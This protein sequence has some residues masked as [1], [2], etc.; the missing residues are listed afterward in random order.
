MSPRMDEDIEEIAIIGM[1]G[2]FPGAPDIAALWRLLLRKE[3]GI[4]TLSREELLASGEPPES[5]DDPSYVPRG[6]FL[7]DAEC[8][9][10]DF[11]G[12]PAS[13]ASHTDPQQRLFLSHSYLALE[14]AGYAPG[15]IDVPVAVFAG[16]GPPSYWL[17]Q[18]EG[19]ISKDLKSF[20]SIINND[21]DFIATRTSYRLDLRGPS[22]DVQTACSTSLV[23]V[24]LACQSLLT[25]SCDMALAGGVAVSAPRRRGYLASAGMINSP[26]GICR[27]FDAAADGT[28]VGEGVGVVCLK[29][30]SEAVEDGDYVYAVIKA[31]AIN[32]DGAG[33]A[34]FTAPS[35]EGQMRA[36]ELAQ[37]LAGVE[38]GELGFIEAHG[39]G[40][41]IGDPIEVRALTRAF[42]RKTDK[43]G[44]CRLGSIKANLG[45]LDAAAGITGLIKAVLAVNTGIVPPMRNF[46]SP[47][48]L[49]ELESS[50][51]VV[52]REAERW[53]G[54][55]GRRLAGVSS[56]GIGGTNAHA[57]VESPPRARS[58]ASGNADE[59]SIVPLLLCAKDPGALDAYKK[60]IAD[61]IEGNP[62]IPVADIALRISRTRSVLP[63]RWASVVSSRGGLAE[64]LRDASGVAEHGAPRQAVFAFPGQGSQF[65]GMARAYYGKLGAFTELIDR[66][67]EIAAGLGIRDA[68]RYLLLEGFDDAVSETEIAQP[69]LYIVEYALAMEIVAA[70]IEPAA[71]VGHSVGEYAAAAVGGALG[72]EDGLRL[73]ARRGYWMQRAPRGAMTAVAASYEQVLPLLT[74]GV[75][76]S[77]FNAATQ[78]VVSGAGGDIAL[79]EERTSAAGI[80][81]TRIRTSHAFHSP[82][83]DGILGSYAKDVQEAVFT[84]L[85]VPMLSNL[86]GAWIDSSIDW[87]EYCVRQ[88]RQA[89]RFDEC[90]RSLE[91]MS[92]PMV[93][94]VGPGRAL[95][96]FVRSSSSA[97]IGGLAM[98]PN[99]KTDEPYFRKGL[100]RLWM[101]GLPV[102]WPKMP[103]SDG[104]LILFS[105]RPFRMDR[106][107]WN[108]PGFRA[109]D[110]PSGTLVAE[111]AA[112]SIRNIWRRVLGEAP[113]SDDASFFLSGGDSFAGIQ[114]V[115]SLRRDMGMEIRVQDLL[116]H[117]SVAAL[118]ILHDRAVP[119]A[120]IADSDPFLFPI[121]T[122][123]SKPLLFL[124]A[125]A[126]ENR[127]F[128]PVLGN[129]YEE[130]FF[131]Y[132]SNMIANLGSEQPLYGFKPKG[133][134]MGERIHS[135][136]EIMATRYLSSMKRIQPRGPYWIGG[137]CVG[138]IVAYEMARQLAAE[139]EPV[140][141]LILM[142]TPRP[143][144]W[145]AIREDALLS[146]RDLRR[147]WKRLS[148]TLKSEGLL[149]CLAALRGDLRFS[150]AI[151]FPVGRERRMQ[152]RICNGSRRYQRILFKYRPKGFEGRTS[153]LVNKE[154]NRKYLMMGWRRELG[155]EVNL[156]EI[157]GDHVTRLTVSGGTVGEIIK[158]IIDR[159]N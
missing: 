23:A 156:Y 28:L 37:E 143:T 10:A 105:G 26:T 64:E 45:H 35:V 2:A 68:R 94:E 57:I 58:T 77:V 119:S 111:G 16:E 25:W 101:S 4:S 86:D 46:D 5:I 50:P 152:R 6:G 117:P 61:F 99:A 136:V 24:G 65:S 159:R 30:L 113:S 56:F 115:E 7:D 120:P 38:P 144:L 41:P 31:V 140:A 47:N 137:E 39:T 22:I 34:G 109:A 126:H 12:I 91:R 73:V 95:T 138:G 18:N 53:E 85:R 148:G 106:F 154:W 90:I 70:G 3:E 146:Y 1:S 69:L 145:T 139:G 151:L 114:M 74:E 98:L 51:F 97:K 9:D 27:P 62:D 131:R 116:L 112:A 134:A 155:N 78:V 14:D 13:E 104:R 108:S 100:A 96:G 76:V 142:D 102:I 63:C 84:P 157:P 17:L 128:D 122:G 48:P 72:F 40:T 153:L 21:K 89:V 49:L 11:F 124:V 79:L 107:W 55:G 150:L 149:A 52:N 36:I 43:V 33:K 141:N 15:S 129:S 125:G 42:R 147:S 59:S 80:K 158:S 60:K 127:Y 29:R 71:L 20:R 135:S 103:V 88:L 92:G 32:N 121:Q 82:M 83:M 110:A 87:K 123:G 93:I 66:G 44:Y 130:D 118:S 133:L 54:I 19:G 132:F 81:Y 75:G 8:F 67:I